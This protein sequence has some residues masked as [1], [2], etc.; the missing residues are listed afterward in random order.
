MPG[1]ERERLY[2]R[3]RK[4]ASFSQLSQNVR[5]KKFR[6]VLCSQT[7]YKIKGE[8]ELILI[9]QGVWG[10]G[11]FSSGL[12]AFAQQPGK[13]TKTGKPRRSRPIN[14][15]MAAAPGRNPVQQPFLLW[16]KISPSSRRCGQRS[17]RGRRRKCYATP[18][19]QRRGWL[20]AD[21]VQ[22]GQQPERWQDRSSAYRPQ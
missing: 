19:T 22:S 1:R 14:K 18:R 15:E 6:H 20:P 16:Y 11:V 13:Q 9:M 8:I 10:S 21:T 17:W 7:F 4:N 5:C 3:A 2:D 12:L